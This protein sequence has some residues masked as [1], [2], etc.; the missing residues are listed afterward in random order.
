MRKILLVS[1][2]LGAALLAKAGDGPNLSGPNVSTNFYFTNPDN[3]VTPI[4]K[5][6]YGLGLR[7]GYSF[8]SLIEWD[9]GG[10]YTKHDFRNRPVAYV[11][12]MGVW[13]Y[14]SDPK[15]SYWA[16]TTDV[17]FHFYPWDTRSSIYFGGGLGYNNMKSDVPGFFGYGA[18]ATNNI[19]GGEPPTTTP[20]RITWPTC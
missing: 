12:S 20:T 18:T 13:R 10:I 9:I 1:A 19:P 16:A 2:L 4:L 17:N 15:V 8:N 14:A 7:Y 5:D 11:D 6:S 3:A